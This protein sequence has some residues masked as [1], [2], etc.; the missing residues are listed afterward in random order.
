MSRGAARIEP[1]AAAGRGRVLIVDDEEVIATTL[2]E[3]LQGEG[4]D[5]R[6]AADAASALALIEAFEPDVALC[7]VQLPGLDGLE[8]LDRLLAVR[9][10][11]MVMMITAYATV[12][13]AVAAFRR[14]AQDYLMKPV[15][16]DELLAKIDRLMGYRRL[17]IENQALRRQLHADETEEPLVGRSPA[18]QAVRDLIRKVA[19]TRSNVLITGESGTGKELVARALHAQGPDPNAPFLAVNCAAIPQDLLENQLFGAVRGAYTGADRDRTGLFVAAGRGTV[20]LDEIGELN[21]PTQAKLLR[22]I[23]TKE[24]LPVG[25]TRPVP[26]SARIVAA[27]N[28]DLPA[29]VAAGRFRADLFYR[30]DVVNIRTPP[31][32]DHPEDIPELV[33]ALL[34]RHARK[35]GKRVDG[36]DNEVMRLLMAAPWR[37]NVRE[38][39]NALER[40]AILGDGPILTAAD[41][42]A[43]LIA[44]AEAADTGDD[45]RAVLAL[46]ERQHIRRVLAR[47]H[48]DKREAARR[49]NMGLSSLYRKLEEHQIR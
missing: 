18:I 46:A 19:P 41:F 16:F 8:L 14:G 23:E 20:F 49:L 25:A 38:L 26:F 12:E 47:C 4:Y 33:A 1:G 10:E 39:D 3:F 6:T 35:L 37:G 31:L 2:Q 40:A 15:I 29:E 34:A 32:R 36:V 45:L 30:L 48:G 11:T 17:L 44:E 21:L 13:N 43:D 5:A 28:K 9:P 22:A 7:D 27:T 24:V 42:P